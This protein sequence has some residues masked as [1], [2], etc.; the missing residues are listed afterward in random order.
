MKNQNRVMTIEGLISEGVPRKLAERIINQKSS[1]VSYQPREVY[2]QFRATELEAK[3]VAK[4]FPSLIIRK[5][6]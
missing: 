1:E 4:Q 3:K 5:K 2:W 6:Y